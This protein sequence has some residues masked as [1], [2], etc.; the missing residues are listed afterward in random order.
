MASLH[1]ILKRVFYIRGSV[2]NQMMRITSCESIELE[3]VVVQCKDFNYLQVQ[4]IVKR[5][6]IQ[7]YVSA[8]VILFSPFS[9]CL[10]VVS[11]SPVLKVSFSD[12][13]LS[14]VCLSQFHPTTG[15]ISTNLICCFRS[16]IQ[17]LL[18]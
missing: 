11:S 4:K 14:V 18:G 9:L 6:I 8:W 12:H 16:M 5:E 7:V 3:N 2:M 13:L 17:T 15:P 1:V 10:H